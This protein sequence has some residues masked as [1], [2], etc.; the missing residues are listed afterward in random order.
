MIFLL[1]TMSIFNCSRWLVNWFTVYVTFPLSE[2]SVGVEI[3]TLQ[4]GN[5]YCISDL[6]FRS[7]FNISLDVEWYVSF[8]PA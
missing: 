4:S 6:K 2:H 3:N 7:L 5:F 8:V 1:S